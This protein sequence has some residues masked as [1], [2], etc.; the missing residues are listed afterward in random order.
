MI[1]VSTLPYLFLGML[2]A[3]GGTS[4]AQLAPEGQ[5]SREYNGPLPKTRTATG[6]ST[7]GPSA[8]PPPVA[9]GT[10]LADTLYRETFTGGLGAWR[11][12][13]ANTSRPLIWIHRDPRTAARRDT[14][15]GAYTYLRFVSP[16]S[17]TGFAMINFDSL[18]SDEG[19]NAGLDGPN[20]D[21]SLTSPVI[22]L[23]NSTEQLSIQYW[24]MLRYCCAPSANPAFVSFSSDGGATF[25]DEVLVSPT[26]NVNNYFGPI[27]RDAQG[28]AVSSGERNFV[29]IP[30]KYNTSSNFA[31][32]LRYSGG[33]YAW[34]VDDIIITA[35]PNNELSLNPDFIAVAP[36]FR[37]P[38]SQVEGQNIYFVTDVQN[39]GALAQ[40]PRVVVTIRQLGPAGASTIY[41][42]DSLQYP[43]INADETLEN[44]VFEKFTPMPSEAGQYRVT[45]QVVN[46]SSQDRDF[47]PD[48]NTTA[49][50]FFV[51][52]SDSLVRYHRLPFLRGASTPA[53]TAGSGDFEL[54]NIYYTP[55]LG[56]EGMR[57]DTI[58]AGYFPQGFGDNSG[59]AF[60]ELR[61][62]GYK[63][64]LNKDGIPSIGTETPTADDELVLLGTRFYTIDR[65]TPESFTTLV[66]LPGEDKDLNPTKVIIPGN[67]GYIGYAVGISYVQA[68]ARGTNEDL[69][70]IGNDGQ[71]DGGAA[72]LVR[73]SLNRRLGRPL[74]EEY[75]TY[76]NFRSADQPAVVFD[77]FGGAGFFL[78][79][80]V[81]FLD[82]LVPTRDEL[83]AREFRL[84]PNPA[85]TEL[86][87]DF[88]FGDRV[89][90]IEFT[91]TNGVS[92]QVMHINQSVS[93]NGRVTIP[94]A[95]LNQGVYF[96]T[97]TAADGAS[98]T[99]R[100][101]I[102]R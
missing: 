31:F 8:T 97:A 25:A 47:L 46:R 40:S 85:S 51:S 83:V 13:N 87:V 76:G 84:S 96:V 7:G 71:F 54:G 3:L 16:T 23:R 27:T 94:V 52:A 65:N 66:A 5:L 77:A 26:L 93:A 63:G 44:N 57:L 67:Q 2:F 6:S 98:T 42:T 100:V 73:D 86:Q 78:N 60:F 17:A 10:P 29:S 69:L 61:T 81:T 35:L 58:R 12:T 95:S 80:D 45:Y 89:G 38:R 72:R 62:Y 30:K 33:Y 90:R 74:G 56:T 4:Y 14:L 91:V 68:Q 39:N 43:T 22:D 82:A 79:T 20:V 1:K 18:D 37:T 53:E 55:N 41:Y 48:N 9:P 75:A 19:A 24:Q 70:F 102:Q 49:Y 50:D 59:D 36:N 28:F 34:A 11:R 15:T 64:D 99:R 21:Q 92:Q 88:D 32:R 101:L